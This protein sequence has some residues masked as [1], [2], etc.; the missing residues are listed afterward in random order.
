[1][2]SR[3]KTKGQTALETAFVVLFIIISLWAVTT[4]TV[5]YG[6]GIDKM[7][8]A[9]MKAQGISLELSM[10][11]VTTHLVRVDEAAGASVDVYVVSENCNEAQTRFSSEIDI[12]SWECSNNLYLD[13][14]FN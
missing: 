6:A 13:E 7:S 2:K 5:R 12:A 9:R 11:G 8:Q 4:K 1:M 10:E 3:M 14:E